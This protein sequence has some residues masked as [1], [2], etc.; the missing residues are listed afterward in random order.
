MT[1]DEAIKHCEEVAEIKEKEGSLN[2]ES[3]MPLD[4]FLGYRVECL[5]C[6]AEYRQLAEWLKELERYRKE[7]PKEIKN[8]KI[9]Q[10]DALEAN[11]KTENYNSHLAEYIKG[12]ICGLSYTE[13]IIAKILG[14]VNADDD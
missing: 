8:A 14:E 6:A 1:L 11:V 3:F 13:G 5:K 4:E 7:L 2:Q 9:R 12:Y 10:V